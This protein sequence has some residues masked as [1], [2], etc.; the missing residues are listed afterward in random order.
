MPSDG[1]P[2]S[3]SSP[4]QQLNA[5]LTDLLERTPGASRAVLVSGDGI[6]LSY[7]GMGTDDADRLAATVS[8]LFLLAPQSFPHSSGRTHQVVVE[9]DAGFFLVMGANNAFT[10]ESASKTALAVAT[11]PAANVG[12]AGYEMQRFVAS[13]EEHLVVKARANTFSGPGL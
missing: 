1:T 9:H 2:T 5:L 10:D 7:S 13:L 12:Q 11:T 6:K 3:T 4:T 8:S